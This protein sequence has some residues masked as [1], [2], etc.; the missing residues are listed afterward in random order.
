MNTQ[1]D[2]L[3]RTQLLLGEDVM[4]RI[5]N[6]NVIIF[7]IGGVGSW[8]A[9]SLVRSGV[10]HLTIVDADVICP[11]NINRQLMATSSTVGQVKV[12]ALKARL[13]DINPSAHIT[14]LQQ[15]YSVE[16][17]DQFSLD[18][19]DYV[20]DCIDSLAPK[21]LLI[22]NATASSC[23]FFSS[24]GAALKL[25]PTRVKVAEFWKVEGCPLAARLRAMFRKTK[26]YPSHKF[27]CVFSDEVHPNK[28]VLPAEQD[29]AMSFHKKCTN[30]AL[31]HI[32]AIFGFALAG[33]VIQHISKQ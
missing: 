28:G 2:Y 1:L 24:M 25:D 9:E 13:L 22:R 27:Q 17:Q 26:Q 18:E 19:Y 11:T 23:H 14:A 8:T 32:T 29:S 3:S 10:Q 21:A 5:L 6:A 4:N 12:E 30:G 33:L 7:G 16:T 15:I 31:A 20:L